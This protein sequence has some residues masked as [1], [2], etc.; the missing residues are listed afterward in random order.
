MKNYNWGIL[1]AGSIAHEFAKGL[2]L[3]P[4]AVA[5]SV[6]SRTYP[7]AVR[8]ADL[9]DFKVTHKELNEFLN[10]DD[11]D[12]IYIATPNHLH[13]EHAIKCLEAGKHV[14]IEKPFALSVA[15]AQKIVTAARENQCF[16]M[17]AMWS[18]FMPVYQEVKK[19][20]QERVLGEIKY[21]SASFGEAIRYN[22]ESRLFD[23]ETGGGCLL[24]LGVYPVSLALML[25]G[26]PE[27]V[28]GV[29]R[30]AQSGVD[31]HDH[32]SLNYKNGAI[33][34]V[35]CS[36][37]CKMP[38][39][40][41]I[42]GTHGSIEI[43][44]PIYRPDCYR[45]NRY[46]PYEIQPFQGYSMRDKL[47]EIPLFSGLLHALGNYLMNPITK[48]KKTKRLNYLANGY[49]YEAHEVIRVLDYGEFESGIMPLSDSIA[50]LKITDKLRNEWG[51]NYPEMKTKIEYL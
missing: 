2:K 10:D 43:P 42:S 47:H 45:L 35:R 19:L 22:P 37:D 21:F 3:V 5:H 7:K 48:F 6:H 11:L 8:F 32:I 25:L 18:R 1:G 51:V 31:T 9:F 14:L 23:A 39:T 29:C 44:G 36:F 41:W 17:E 24:D 15:Q 13:C 26:E 20:L 46:S 4:H 38:N 33:A 49:Q 30:K 50:T 34:D 27:S 28:L 12:I 16:C 40:V